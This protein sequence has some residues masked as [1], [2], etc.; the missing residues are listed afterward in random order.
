MN[1]A[2][3]LG[4]IVIIGTMVCLAKR[5]E[6]RLVLFLAGFI[7]S[8]IAL[9]PMA[10]MEGF[11]KA[12]KNGTV[13]EPIVAS[14]GF[15][16]VMKATKC[17]A[18]LVHLMIG[19]LRRFGFF[20][21]PGAVLV[22]ALINIAI[23]SSSGC[24]AAVGAIIIPLLMRMGVHPG[25]AASTVFL[26]TYGSPL[27]NPG[28]HQVVIASK[29]S[30][31]VPMDFITFAAMPVLA[32]AIACAV[33]L[34]V[35][36]VVTKEYKGYE[37]EA[38]ETNAADFK[39]SYLKAVVPIIPIVL[40]LLAKTGHLPGM[41]KLDIS[42][43]M[44]IGSVIAYL[45]DRREVTP[46]QISERFFAGMGQAFGKAYG[47]VTCS[48][49]FVAGMN[50]L[51]LVKS[52]IGFMA[53]NEGIARIAG[54]VGP[55]LL[56]TITGSGDAAAISFNTAVTVHAASFGLDPLHLGAA[57][58]GAAG[59]GRTMSPIAGAAIICSGYADCSPMELAKRNAIPCIVGAIIFVL[60]TL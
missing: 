39:V 13:I 45:V 43:V 22:T 15:A 5:I 44:I 56:A 30:E 24:S 58:A 1:I 37:Y 28:Y 40:L 34:C 48:L 26:G 49:I 57:V 52:L 32:V 6:S 2:M 4:V 18:H 55:F 14:L 20:I 50:A 3:I 33:L 7:L 59:L 38:E 17:D 23:T 9:N 36:A 60:M 10:A 27:V 29:V 41:G 46:T 11:S 21:V 16:Y 31:H 8:C 54:T 53:A 25:L 51:G 19:P 42:H 12:M 47:I 35:I